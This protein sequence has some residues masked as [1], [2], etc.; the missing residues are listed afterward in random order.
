LL[1][2]ADQRVA[3][4]DIHRDRIRPLEMAFRASCPGATLVTAWFCPV[5]GD[6]NNGD[7]TENVPVAEAADLKDKKDELRQTARKRRTN[8]NASPAQERNKTWKTS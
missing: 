4:L 7:A 6:P 1:E 8:S 3:R 5:E 2:D